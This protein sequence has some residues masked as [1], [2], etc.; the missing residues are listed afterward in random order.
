MYAR[1]LHRRWGGPWDWDLTLKP[2]PSFP[3]Q[4]SFMTGIRRLQREVHHGLGIGEPV[5]LCCSTTTVGRGASIEQA[6]HGDLVLSVEQMVARAPF[7]GDDVTVRQIPGGVHDYEYLVVFHRKNV[8]D[9]LEISFVE[10]HPCGLLPLLVVEVT[11]GFAY[12]G[13]S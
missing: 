6:R 1:V 11:E 7:L 5:L 10:N 12:V 2:S 9:C 13:R 8:D 3:V 4:A